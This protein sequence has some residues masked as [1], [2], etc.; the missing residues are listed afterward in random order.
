MDVTV[1]ATDTLSDLAARI[2]ADATLAAQ[3]KASVVD[4]KLTLESKNSGLANAIT[5]IAQP[6]LEAFDSASLTEARAAQEGLDLPERRQAPLRR[7]Q[8]D[9]MEPSL[10]H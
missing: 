9:D 8:L 7:M 10:R 4:N 3:V 5:V 1:N 6:G 2:N